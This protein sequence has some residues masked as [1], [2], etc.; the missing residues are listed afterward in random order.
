MPNECTLLILLGLSVLMST[1]AHDIQ[2]SLFLAPTTPSKHLW[3]GGFGMTC[4][5]R[6][7]PPTGHRVALSGQRVAGWGV[8]LR[9]YKYHEGG[10][11]EAANSEPANAY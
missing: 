11:T 9:D 8:G 10:E 5:I 1:L 2:L 3:C 7:P 4:L 6:S